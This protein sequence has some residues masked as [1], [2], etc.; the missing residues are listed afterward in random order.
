LFRAGPCRPCPVAVLGRKTRIGEIEALSLWPAAI[1]KAENEPMYTVSLGF[2]TL[3][4]QPVD[5]RE[6]F[7]SR[8]MHSRKVYCV[9]LEFETVAQGTAPGNIQIVRNRRAWP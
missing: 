2:S 5:G 3:Q 7:G 4:E 8:K 6:P 1:R 9:R